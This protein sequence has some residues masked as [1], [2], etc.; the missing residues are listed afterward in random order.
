MIQPM[1]HL[2]TSPQ[3]RLEFLLMMSGDRAALM[4]RMRSSLMANDETLCA[5][6]QRR[7]FAATTLF[8]RLTWMIHSYA[9]LLAR[10]DRARTQPI[11]AEVT[12]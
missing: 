4:E 2:P 3:K 5:D 1:L 12:A 6:T 10:S 11:S 9:Q 7:L 8:E